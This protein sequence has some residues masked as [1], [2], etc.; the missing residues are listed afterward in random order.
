MSKNTCIELKVIFNAKNY[1]H[2]FS[3]LIIIFSLHFLYFYCVLSGVVVMKMIMKRIK[4]RIYA[5]ILYRRLLSLSVFKYKIKISSFSLMIML[6]H[7]LISQWIKENDLNLNG[8]NSII[9]F[10]HRSH[11]FFHFFNI[12]VIIIIIGDNFTFFAKLKFKSKGWDFLLTFLFFF[13]FF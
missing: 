5:R 13:L 6:S 10:W 3:N 11:I 12:I 2:N 4:M 9:F 7:K 8:F 1:Q